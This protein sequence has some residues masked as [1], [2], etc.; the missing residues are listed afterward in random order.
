M[1]KKLL[2]LSLGIIMVLSLM[3][4]CGGNNGGSSTPDTPPADGS[5]N[6]HLRSVA[7]RLKL[8]L[9]SSLPTQRRNG[10]RF[11]GFYAVIRKIHVR[12]SAVERTVNY[13]AFGYTLF[14]LR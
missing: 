2:A 13:G 1:S 10:F 4:G 6:P 11:V 14:I 5:S 9:P 12:R 7:H 8:G 3:A